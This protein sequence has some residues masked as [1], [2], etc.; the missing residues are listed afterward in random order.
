MSEWT[1]SQALARLGVVLPPRPQRL[2]SSS[3]V[4]HVTQGSDQGGLAGFRAELQAGRLARQRR[5]HAEQR[6]AARVAAL[7]FAEVRAYL[8]DR[9]IEREWLLAEVAAELADGRCGG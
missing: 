8:E 1:I 4:L 5:R 7:G 3:E 9:L 2:S 6:I